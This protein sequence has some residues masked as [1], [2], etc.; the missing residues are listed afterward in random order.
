M[1]VSSWETLT[2]WE[3]GLVLMAEAMLSKVLIQFSVDGWGQIK[4]NTQLWIWLVME[5]SSV[6]FSCSIVS[7]SLRPHELQQARPPCPSPNPVVHSNSHPSSQWCHP[8]ISFSV[9]P[10]PPLPFT[11]LLFSAICNASSDKH[12]AFLHFFFLGK[13]LITASYTMSRTSIRSSSGTLSIKSNPLNL[14]SPPLHNCKGFDLG[15][16]WIV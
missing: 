10:F 6:Q 8:A 2:V 12:F 14:L 3:M 1:E 16:S 15:H 4:N 13:V 9:V 11:S 7:N 5:V